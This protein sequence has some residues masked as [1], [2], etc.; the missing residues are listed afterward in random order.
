MNWHKMDIKGIS[1]SFIDVLLP[2]NK[3]NGLNAFAV[4]GTIYNATASIFYSTVYV[5]LSLRNKFLMEMVK[6]YDFV[7]YNMTKVPWLHIYW[8]DATRLTGTTT[9]GYGTT[10]NGYGT[11]ANGY[12]TT[13][14]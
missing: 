6:H 7:W 3:V 4:I 2:P 8:Y 14:N 9:N 12:S 10:T 5:V 13:T 1:A 11:T